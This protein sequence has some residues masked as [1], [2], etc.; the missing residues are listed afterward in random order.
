[1]DRER[2]IENVRDKLARCHELAEQFPV[3]PAAEL[4]RE[5]EA[6]LLEAV[7]AL[8]QDAWETGPKHTPSE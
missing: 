2:E 6:Q 3:G 8:E 4:I 7:R 1:M 5:I